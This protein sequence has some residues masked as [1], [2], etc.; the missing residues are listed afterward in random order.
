MSKLSDALPMFVDDS[1]EEWKQH[2]DY[3]KFWISNQG[4]FRWGDSPETGHRIGL[5]SS[6]VGT[7]VEL[8]REEGLDEPKSFTATQLVAKLFVP[9]PR[10][11]KHVYTIDPNAKP[12]WRASN[13]VWDKSR[14]R[15]YCAPKDPVRQKRGYGAYSCRYIMNSTF[16]TIATV[17]M[18]KGEIEPD[19]IE[20]YIQYRLKEEGI[21]AK[22]ERWKTKIKRQMGSK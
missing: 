11:C 15:S 3:P 4:K 6:G 12:L 14:D 22:D 2:P 16:N 1:V 20:D 8:Y 21:R 13:L 7:Q 18:M 17:K 10:G 5:C 9:N 19:E